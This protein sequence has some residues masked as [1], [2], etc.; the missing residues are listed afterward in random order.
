MRASF[1]L[2]AALG[3][4]LCASVSLATT[5]TSNVP[6]GLGPTK[7]QEGPSV[8]AYPSIIE[9]SDAE[10]NIVDVNVSLL[11]FR[12]QRSADMQ[13]LLVSPSDTKVIFFGGLN[14]GDGDNAVDLTFD[15][16]A[17]DFAP[18]GPIDHYTYKPTAHKWYG[19]EVPKGWPY[20]AT[21]PPPGDYHF[22]L[23]AMDGTAANGQWELYAYD[24]WSD[25]GGII[26]GWSIDLVSANVPEPMML[27]A[28]M[29]LMV[30]CRQRQ[31]RR[32][33]PP[34]ATDGTS[35]V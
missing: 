25:D 28:P 32:R 6:I 16:E 30:M 18:V 11:G 24:M 2:P 33:L 7:Y 21:N 17:P 27:F 5:Y 13:F 1:T 15:D 8:D 19:F 34:C 31:F 10:H 14:V 12:H 26:Q 23:S 4:T 22:T 35:S 20:P 3:L 9:V 29:G